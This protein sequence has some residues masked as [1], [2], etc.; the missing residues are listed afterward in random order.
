MSDEGN[1][2]HE[3][4]QDKQT[5][6]GFLRSL[7]QGLEKGN[8][9]LSSQDNEFVLNLPNLMKL[10]LKAKKKGQKSKLEIMIDWQEKKVKQD[11]ENNQLS[12][13]S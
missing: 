4:L 3:S 1:F 10:T 11:D 5:I 9:V 12:I 13:S 6:K 2:F 8:I 7:E